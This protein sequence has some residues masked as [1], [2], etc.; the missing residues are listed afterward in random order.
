MRHCA[1]ISLL[2]LISLLVYDHANP[3]TQFP[4]IPVLFGHVRFLYNTTVVSQLDIELSLPPD[5]VCYDEQL[6]D[7]L[8][9]TFRN[10]N[11]TCRYGYQMGF[12]TEHETL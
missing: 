6:C 10:G 1:R 4:T 2:P 11:Y 8:T 7:F 5:Y 3:L 12:W 9:P